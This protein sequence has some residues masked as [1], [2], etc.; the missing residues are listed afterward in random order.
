MVAVQGPRFG[1]VKLLY[2]DRQHK[3]ASINNMKSGEWAEISIQLTDEHHNQFPLLHSSRSEAD[4]KKTYVN[5]KID[6]REPEPLQ[7]KSM[8]FDEYHLI[9]NP[10]LRQLEKMI[11][12]LESTR[13]ETTLQVLSAQSIIRTTIADLRSRIR[14]RAQW[15]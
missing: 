2:F 12:L 11:D 1:A 13:K 6:T 3:K 4:Q 15:P 9:T 8:G 14:A 10:L 7:I 5:I